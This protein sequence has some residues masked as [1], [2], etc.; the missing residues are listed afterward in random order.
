[1]KNFVKDTREWNR[2]SNCIIHGRDSFCSLILY[3]AK[4]H[5]VNRKSMMV[6]GRETIY[7]GFSSSQ[8]VI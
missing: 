2:A 8:S 3:A 1:M 6:I 4:F 5:Y 7:E